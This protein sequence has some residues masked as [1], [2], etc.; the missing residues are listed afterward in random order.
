MKT[1]LVQYG[2][3]SSMVSKILELVP[4]RSEISLYCEP[5]F[6]GGAVYFAMNLKKGTKVILNDKAGY[7]A[8]FW[9]CLNDFGKAK[10]LLRRIGG[11]LYHEGSYRIARDIWKKSRDEQVD[12][13][14]FLPDPV[15][16]AWAFWVAT[17]MAFSMVPG[18]GFGVTTSENSGNHPQKI[19]NRKNR[20]KDAIKRIKNAF[21]YCRDAT[22]VLDK[23]KDAPGA[24]IYC[25][26]PYPD[27]DQGQFVGYTIEDF[28]ALLDCLENVQGKFMLSCYHNEVIDS[29]I[30]K[31]SWK[32]K[33][34]EV[35]CSAA[36]N[37][38]TQREKRTEMVVMNY[39]P[40]KQRKLF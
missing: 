20:L 6:G 30:I 11:T 27:K 35:N 14:G 33:E 24:F 29:R 32:V 8:N 23:I 22:E 19:H 13:R 1:P 4:D 10:V 17:S 18:R 2:G 28:S 40:S 34:F 36:D 39:E 38:G 25:D 12:S 16:K 37:R 21:F 5:F 9:A 15:E 7:V 3:K 26:P 31:N